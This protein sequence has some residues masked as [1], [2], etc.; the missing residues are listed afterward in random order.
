M[1]QS[2]FYKM[3][4]LL[5]FGLLSLFAGIQNAEAFGGDDS[6]LNKNDCVKCHTA[7]VKQVQEGGTK[8]KSEVACLECHDGQHP[9]GSEK[10]ALIPQCT[11]CHDG[12]PHFEVAA[13]CLSCH[14]NPHQPLE[15]SLQGEG[16]KP[17]C[18]TCHPQIIQEIDTN[19]TKHTGFS[20]SYCHDKHRYRPDCL[21]C[22]DVHIEGQ[23]FENCVTCHQAHQPLTLAYTTTVANSDC[24]ACHDDILETL[25]SGPTKH[26][27][28]QCVFCHADKHGNVP[29]CKDCH[30]APHS[31][32]ML[33][34]FASCNECHQSA[35]GLIK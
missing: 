30:D 6:K 27:G 3:A 19:I 10:G 21:N 14:K 26:A 15:I 22:H 13:N 33:S 4:V 2:I 18:N 25:E 17:V 29:S 23:K 12:E 11:D 28:F 24:G 31:S 20:C 8:H 35:H 32:Q 7:I 1:K 9:P 34:K 16:Q 5:G